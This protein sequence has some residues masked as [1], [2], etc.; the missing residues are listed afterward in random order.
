VSRHCVG[1]MGLQVTFREVQVGAAHATHRHL[2][3]DLARA[4]RR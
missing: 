3:K 4:G 2:D 1:A